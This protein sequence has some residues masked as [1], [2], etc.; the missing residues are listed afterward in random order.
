MSY[1]G[2][3]FILDTTL[4]S[5]DNTYTSAAAA[6]FSISNIADRIHPFRVYKSSANPNSSDIEIIYDL[7]A[8]PAKVNA[9]FIDN[10]NLVG[11]KV[12]HATAI[13]GSYSDWLPL[14]TSS[15]DPF[16]E[17]VNVFLDTS[18]LSQN[19]RYLKIVA[20][21]QAPTLA[22]T[23]QGKIGGITIGTD[24][25]ALPNGMA[26]IEITT[27]LPTI[28]TSF[29]GGGSEPTEIGSKF[30]EIA[31]ENSQFIR[32]SQEDTLFDI[33]NMGTAPFVFYENAGD[34]SRAYLV[35][36]T[37]YKTKIQY[38]IQYVLT[39]AMSFTQVI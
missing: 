24:V 38:P 39:G 11:W 28:I 8:S 7:G 3:V 9:I 23:T 34:I 4:Y 13:T 31:L 32:S 1:T 33:V 30:V 16:T 27:N 10:T 2:P 21:Q 14:V 6:G 25:L 37:Q 19:N 5:P 35:R 15:V 17:R 26:N 36:H 12:Q 22:P 29:M 20:P 18:D